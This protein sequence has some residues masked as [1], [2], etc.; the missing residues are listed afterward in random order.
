MKKTWYW[1]G[2]LILVLGSVIFLGASVLV[3]LFFGI[4][5][6]R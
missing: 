1:V 6:E 2:T 5:T 4:E 3:L